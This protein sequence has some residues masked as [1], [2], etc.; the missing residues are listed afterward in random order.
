MLSGPFND[1]LIRCLPKTFSKIRRRVI[2]HIGAE[3]EVTTKRGSVGL[4][5]ARESGRAQPLRV[6]EAATGKRSSSKRAPYEQKKHQT[7]A[8]AKEDVPCR[9]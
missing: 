3:E 2:A 4:T 8:Q 6:H 1:S 7:R 5:R 9:H